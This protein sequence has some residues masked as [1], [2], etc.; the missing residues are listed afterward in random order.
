MSKPSRGDVI[1]AFADC[2]A[3]L[4]Q[5]LQ[6]ATAAEASGMIGMS[7]ILNE[8]Q[9]R[10]EEATLRGPSLSCEVQDGGLA[11]FA[12]RGLAAQQAVEA[13]EAK[14]TADTARPR[15]RRQAM[16]EGL[17]QAD[18]DAAAAKNRKGSARS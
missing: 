17:T 13:L 2:R 9:L 18:R 14:I 11:D 7:P 1:N 12:R 10:F 15:P 5:Y 8:L 16:R 4:A 3:L 6:H